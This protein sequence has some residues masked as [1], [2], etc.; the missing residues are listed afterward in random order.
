MH[1][2]GATAKCPRVGLAVDLTADG[3]L[4]TA[5]RAAGFAEG[6]PVFWLLEGLSMYLAAAANVTLLSAAAALSPPGSVVCVGF[7][8]DASKAPP[9]APFTLEPAA[10]AALLARCG[11]GELSWA[12]FGDPALHFG[13]GP[14]GRAPDASQCFGVAAKP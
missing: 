5:L 13:R 9:S 1:R 6:V 12:R 10:F 3:N 2:L 4:V 14:E 8:G 7:I 11:W